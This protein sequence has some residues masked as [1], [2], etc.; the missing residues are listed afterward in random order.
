MEV[1]HVARRIEI[2]PDPNPPEVARYSVVRYK[3]EKTA[4][5]HESLSAAKQASKALGEVRVARW[6]WYAP[7]A[8]V[9]DDQGLLV[10][11]PCFSERI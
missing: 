9:A 11:I 2:S 1:G 10:Y 5:V 8:Y 7:A 4:S 3:T 6:F